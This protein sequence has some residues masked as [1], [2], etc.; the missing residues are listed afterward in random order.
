MDRRRD[1]TDSFTMVLVIVVVDVVGAAAVGSAFLS[2][3]DA[4]GR[5]LM[6]VLRDS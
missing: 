4:V 1:G 6:T 2:D 3:H 5:A